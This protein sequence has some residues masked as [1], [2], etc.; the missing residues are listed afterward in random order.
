MPFFKRNHIRNLSFSGCL[1]ES[2]FWPTGWPRM[3][4][5]LSGPNLCHSSKGITSEI[6]PFLAVFQNLISGRT[7]KSDGMCPIFFFASKLR[8]VVSIDDAADLGTSYLVLPYLFYLRLP[9]LIFIYVLLSHFI[10]FDPIYLHYVV[11]SIDVATILD[12]LIFSCFI[13]SYLISS[14]LNLS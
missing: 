11:V 9:C 3:G 1:P 10:L 4:G 14:D 8:G 6:D 2:D 5:T 13:L 12:Y 7:Q